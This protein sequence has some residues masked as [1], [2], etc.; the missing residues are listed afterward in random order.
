MTNKPKLI[1]IDSHAL[2]HRSFHALP[3]M[4]SQKGDNLNAVYGYMSVFLKLIKEMNPEYMVAAFDLPQPT[5][6]HEEFEEYKAHRPK[7]PDELISQFNKVKEV[8]RAFGVPVMEMP[9]YEADDVLGTITE[10][11][12]SLKLNVKS[13]ILTGDL[14]TLQL[15]DDEKT[16]VYTLKKGITDTVIYDEKAVFER[17]GLRPDQMTDF[18]GLKGDPSDNIPGVPGVGDKT[19]SALIAKYGSLDGVYEEIEQREKT[20]EKSEKKTKKPTQREVLS[21][22]LIE[23]LI[24]YK[25]QAFLSKKL[26]TI[27][28]DAPIDFDLEDAKIGKYDKEKVEN[29]FKE[30]EFFS[31]INRLPWKQNAQQAQ[32][33][34]GI[35]AENKTSNKLSAIE[36]FNNLTVGK[37]IATIQKFNEG[38]FLGVELAIN[39]KENFFVGKDQAKELK[40]IIENENIKKIGYDLKSLVKIFRKDGIELK[41]IDFDILIAKYVLNPGNISGDVPDAKDFFETKKRLEKEIKEKGLEKVFYE[42]EM[43][44]LSVLAQMEIMG[45]KTDSQYL[46][47]L[48]NDFA[49]RLER[50]EK[51]IYALAGEEFNINSP[52]QI[53][54]ILF[55]KLKIEIKGIRKTPGGAISTSASELNKLRGAHP[56]ADLIL[57]YREIFKL[58]STYVDAL[59]KMI[60]SDGRIHTN[61]N[62]AGTSTGRL[63]SLEPN[64]Q[65]IPIRTDLGASIRKA[66]VADAG[67]KLVSFDYSQI[68]LRLA[69][70]IANDEKM[71]AAFLRGDDIHQMTAS[72][73]FNVPI[74]KVD[75]KM[76]R[77]AK[78][79]NFGV[80]YGMSAKS[81]SE[82]AKIDYADAKKFINEYFSDFSG[83]SKYVENTIAKA[84]KLGY[85]ET[86]LGRRRYIPEILSQSWQIKQAAERMAMNMP[87]QGTAADIIKMA[88]VKIFNELKL[89]E[90]DDVRLLLQV[91][92]ELV[93]EM[94]EQIIQKE[95]LKVKE[96]MENVIKLD[97]PLEVG[98]ERGNNFGDMEEVF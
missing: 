9:G 27:R 62:Q 94:K 44:L 12:K 76:R 97:V 68:E 83:I 29:I 86:L 19:A 34:R 4:A 11:V 61:Y 65:N 23:K 58:K 63:S 52:Q 26:A 80:L 36:Q 69:S 40:E 96:I 71:K 84:K 20:K 35:N 25:D 51:E 32:D 13:I 39:E 75:D 14:D 70:V 38:E 85:V 64:L 31:L 74:D 16:I 77:A 72:E 30:M 55:E 17:F 73:I 59:P 18:K 56:I 88:M 6:R 22:K 28:R 15:V 41:G 42:I 46:S 93:F 67:Y 1:L 81:F 91:H 53:S 89:K 37:E 87:I 47:G 92:D 24:E 3:P 95:V 90:R 48:S 98:V 5:F 82:T 54:K 7:A 49:V 33:E 8:V 43:P 78:T 10:K 79:L 66:F 2:I 50:L 57:D 45:I 21:E 60:A